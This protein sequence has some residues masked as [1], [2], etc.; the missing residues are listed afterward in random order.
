MRVRETDRREEREREKRK[1]GLPEK[2]CN[3]RKIG[4]EPQ[5][6]Q[7]KDEERKSDFFPP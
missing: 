5:V 4:R 6:R 1:K 2:F 3:T 7:R